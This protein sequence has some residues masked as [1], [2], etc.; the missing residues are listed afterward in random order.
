MV[1]EAAPAA[2]L[3]CGTL[4]VP[5]ALMAQ[6][7]RKA[8]LPDIAGALAGW[9]LQLPI[10]A[11]ISV[12]ATAGQPVQRPRDQRLA[13][14]LEALFASR[15]L[16]DLEYFEPAQ[17]ARGPGYAQAF[18][19]AIRGLADAGWTADRL[20]GAELDA[21]HGPRLRDVA[22]VWGALPVD[23]EAPDGATILT[24]A[25]RL[26]HEGSAWWSQ[27]GPV[28]ALLV[29]PQP[30]EL[31]FLAALP[32]VRAAVLR[33][34][35]DR[36]EYRSVVQRIGEAFGDP[37]LPQRLTAGGVKMPVPPERAAP[38]SPRRGSGSPSREQDPAPAAGPRE[39]DR[40]Q[41]FLF[42]PPDPGRPRG[43]RRDGSV[44]FEIHAG[45]EE[46]VEAAVDWVAAEVEQG[47]PLEDIAVLLTEAD[48]YAGMIVERLRALP[49]AEASPT[50]Y[51]ANGLPLHRGA[52]AC[53]VHAVLQALDR[54]LGA[55][56]LHDLLPHLEPLQTADAQ[57]AGGGEQ[58][59][60]TPPSFALAGEVVYAC[61]TPGGLPGREELGLIW[62]DTFRRRAAQARE[63]IS[64]SR[65][66]DDAEEGREVRSRRREEV[67]VDCIE[68]L[69]PAVDD[70][71]DL[72]RRMRADQP[73][74]ELVA[75]LRAFVS[76]HL[77]AAKHR[78]DEFQAIDA[79]LAALLGAAPSAGPAGRAALRA[80]ARCL[81]ELRRPLGEIGEGRIFV[82]TLD[83]AAGLSFG[84]VRIIGLTE[85]TVPP[86][87]LDDAVLPD[88]AA[89]ALEH[90]A[91]G[92]AGRGTP[93]AAPRPDG[94]AARIVRRIHEFVGAV[95][96]ARQRLV[97]S[98]ARQAID[99]Q[100]REPASVFL[101]AAL[102][103]GRGTQGVPT[104]SVIEAE[105]FAPGAAELQAWRDKAPITAGIV[106][107]AVARARW[108]RSGLAEVRSDPRGVP[109]RWTTCG[110]LDV[111][112]LREL[113][114]RR[115]EPQRL[116]EIVGDD[117]LPGL[118][119]QRP[120]SQ[121]R[122]KHLLQCPLRYLLEDVH[123]WT[124]LFEAPSMHE[125][126][127]LQYGTLLHRVMQRFCD[128]FGQEFSRQPEA[129]RWLAVIGELADEEFAE[130][131]LEYPLLGEDVERRERQRLRGDARKLVQMDS[132]RRPGRPLAAEWHFG[133]DQEVAL[134]LGEDDANVL[135]VR[136]I[137]DRVEARDGSL[138]VWDIKSGQLRRP[139]QPCDFGEDGQLA[140]YAAALQHARLPDGWPRKVHRVG[141]ISPREK[142]LG[143]RTYEGR[144]VD[145]LL[146]AGRG[147]WTLARQLLEE[148]LFPHAVDDEAC[149]F[150]HFKEVCG[151]QRGAATLAGLAQAQEPALQ[152]FVEFGQLRKKR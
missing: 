71:V 109:Q 14:E 24:R 65:G 94:T 127:A 81:G 58:R 15:R 138:E 31:S 40:L 48:P 117:R 149:K 10:D 57:P 41:A 137:V 146:E 18:A 2:G 100:I 87:P 135:F 79:E 152:A 106:R 90:G 91:P 143:R 151:E 7:I 72:F 113:Y 111:R 112:R 4:L 104:E 73:L 9:R 74:R 23:R 21:L 126:N 110:P 75:A 125:I 121:S 134:A 93:G 69:L 124:A 84:A 8:A 142:G 136:G 88:A 47:T 52:L 17:L 150:C 147:W 70:V 60:R 68:G 62:V 38:R 102:A 131:V 96:S 27:P 82:G 3:P 13:L 56:A 148:R 115:L 63:R 86:A 12:L 19:A 141:L 54:H 59:R 30:V 16:G 114:G 97:L 6:A 105:Y 118:T 145:E 11:A 55:E 123:G 5:G 43:M 99:G 26:L 128:R 76:R 98:T 51:V 61:G 28:I 130:F 45:V 44:H 37:E 80:V 46:E 133:F 85:G 83:R 122:L 92:S 34:R 53:G 132:A 64:R 49:W 36:P 20:A 120:I 77:H 89:R 67:L 139:P 101:E 107:R 29:W 108:G 66:A 1:H 35:P 95:S 116:P 42:E 32:Q 140:L 129:E 33:G 144:A 103:V 78:P 25:A 39:I 119:A 50:V 22:R